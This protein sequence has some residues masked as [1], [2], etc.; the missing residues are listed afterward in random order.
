[1][2]PVRSVLPCLLFVA[3]IACRSDPETPPAPRAPPDSGTGIGLFTSP[4]QG[5]HVEPDL[6]LA[7]LLARYTSTMGWSLLVPEGAREKLAARRCQIDQ[8]FD[9]PPA[10]VHG[11][12]ESLARTNGLLLRFEHTS[13]PVVLQVVD[14]DDKEQ[15]DIPA[16]RALV[17]LAEVPRWEAHPVHMIT[18]QIPLPAGN[19]QELVRSLRAIF[20][21]VARGLV[22]QMGET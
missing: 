11:F 3:A 16:H 19:A 13:A 21:D 20:G 9:V 17:P 12:V 10:S 14:P 4:A 15:G 2:I 7:D 1:M 5:L 6:P 8:P 22:Q 18:T